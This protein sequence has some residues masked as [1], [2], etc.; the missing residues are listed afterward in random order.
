MLICLQFTKHFHYYAIAFLLFEG[1]TPLMNAFIVMEMQ[2]KKNPTKPRSALFNKVHTIIGALFFF[3]FFFLRILFGNWMLW[4]FLVEG[5]KGGV[6]I[7]RTG[8]LLWALY[9]IAALLANGLNLYW[10]LFTLLPQA[11]RILSGKRKRT[12]RL[13]SSSKKESVGAAHSS[14]TN[15]TTSPTHENTPTSRK[16]TS[17]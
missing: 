3:Q 6:D 7:R 14:A 10:F 8:Y 12:N 17:N 11:I 16:K 9:V 4:R 15:K 13:S 1:S 5:V 2:K